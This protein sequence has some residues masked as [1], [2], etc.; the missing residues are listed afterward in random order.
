MVAKL[1]MDLKDKMITIKDAQGFSRTIDLYSDEAFDLISK[2]W[3]KVG[4]NQKYTYTFTWLGRPIIQ[5]PED[6]VRS[7]E[8]I[9]RVKPDIIIETGVAHGG[10]LIF[11]ASLCKIMGKG[12]VVGVD[13]EI[14]PHNRAAVEEHALFEYITL[15]EGSSILPNV[16]DQVRKVIKQGESVMVFLD[17]NHSKQH[18]LEE[19]RAYSSLVTVGSYIV[20]TDGIMKDLSD[21]PRG[22]EEW[23]W[24][25]PSDAAIEFLKERKDFILEQPLWQFNESSL[26]KNIT[27]WLGAWLKRV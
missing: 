27:H 25:N 19:L 18:V 15:I 9:F 11:Y 20:A 8:V 24:D 22:K 14:R 7:Q 16:V 1:D 23:R 26:Y 6:M 17:S 2:I 12:H 21:V 4:W 10:S 5:L 3:L 13:I